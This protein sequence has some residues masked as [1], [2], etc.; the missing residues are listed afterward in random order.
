MAATTTEEKGFEE[1]GFDFGR[2]PLWLIFILIFLLVMGYQIA[3]SE[4]YREAFNFI[5]YGHKDGILF[6]SEDQVA[7]AKELGVQLNGRVYNNF[8]EFVTTGTGIILGIRVTILAF[9]LSMVLGLFA[10]LGRISKNFLIRN[11]A[12]TYIEV[13]RGI[14]VL[15]LLLVFG[16]SIFPD[17]TE[18]LG[19]KR[20]AMPMEY[21]AAITLAVIYGA[22]IAE[23]FRAGIESVPKGQ[24]EAARSTGMTH[25]QAMR[26]IILPQ[27]IR[28]ILPALGNDFIALLK[29]SSLVSAL[30][31][32][33]ITQLSRLYVGTT[34]RF[35]E[36]Y[37]ILTFLYL[38]LT[39]ALSLLQQWYARRMGLKQK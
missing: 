19:F 38:S 5:F 25:Y 7:Q 6:L 11:F 18:A 35:R 20:S 34:F 24:M 14:P 28:N 31:V 26:Y 23:V 8:F 29:D 16:F 39:I 10:G 3:T 33:D 15:V 12:I 1:G 36:S 27:A 21:R 37:L 9:M 32:S 30:A 2:I 13:I 17:V 4:T 22:F